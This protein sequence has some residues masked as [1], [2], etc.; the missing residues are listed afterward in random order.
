[1][2]QQVS[3]SGIRPPL[4][5]G[6]VVFRSALIIGM[7]GNFHRE[8]VI[9]HELGK[10]V[11][12]GVGSGV[13]G[14][15]VGLEKEI[16]EGQGEPGFPG[17]GNAGHGYIFLSF[18]RAC[19]LPQ[20][21][22]VADRVEPFALYGVAVALPHRQGDEVLP[23]LWVGVHPGDFF[24]GFEVIDDKQGIRWCAGLPGEGAGNGGDRY[25]AVGFRYANFIQFFFP[26]GFKTGEIGGAPIC[27][28]AIAPVV[29]RAV[30]VFAQIDGWGPFGPAIA[31]G[32]LGSSKK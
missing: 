28:D 7:A 32:R 11:E 20:I 2:L 26:A 21:N 30:A 3:S 17:F 24:P 9:L 8:V 22:M 14:V 19:S 1:M 12:L 5:K 6:F 18:Q 23:G 25:G 31:K 15:A 27:A 29:A 10:P 13:N 16:F 4:R